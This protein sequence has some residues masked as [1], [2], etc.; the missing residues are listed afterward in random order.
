MTSELRS[1]VHAAVSRYPSFFEEGVI[2]EAR[3]AAALEAAFA[4]ALWDPEHPDEAAQIYGNRVPIEMSSDAV[5]GHALALMR[6]LRHEGYCIGEPLSDEGLTCAVGAS[7]G[8]FEMY[9][10]LFD[11]ALG[12]MRQIRDASESTAIAHL[13]TLCPDSAL[14]ASEMSADNVVTDSVCFK[15]PYAYKYVYKYKCGGGIFDWGCDVWGEFVGA[16]NVQ[17]LASG[18]DIIMG[19]LPAGVR[20]GSSCFFKVLYDL[21]RGK[22]V[23]AYLLRQ[24]KRYFYMRDAGSYMAH[25]VLPTCSG[26]APA[27]YQARI[28]YQVVQQ[29]DFKL[30]YEDS[31]SLRFGTNYQQTG[32][33]LV[34]AQSPNMFPAPTAAKLVQLSPGNVPMPSWEYAFSTVRAWSFDIMFGGIEAFNGWNCSVYM[35]ASALMPGAGGGATGNQFVAWRGKAGSSNRSL[36]AVNYLFGFKSGHAPLITCPGQ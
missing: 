28:P 7:V 3:V 1:V 23:L 8:D 11:P 5:M 10:E 25:A 26:L 27:P 33:P 34:T 14:A 6:P 20:C 4:D 13:S 21:A 24:E 29:G 9:G 17:Y 18:S 19:V 12:S 2:T 32:G 31:V 22:N 36:P 35:P 30:P 16:V 15:L